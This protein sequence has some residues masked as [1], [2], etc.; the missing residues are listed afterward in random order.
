LSEGWNRATVLFRDYGGAVA[1][2]TVLV[3]AAVIDPGGV[4]VQAIKTA[5][6]AVSAAG[7]FRSAVGCG[8]GEPSGQSEGTGPYN[9]IED[10]AHLVFESPSGGFF[11]FDIPAPKAS[12]CVSGTNL[13]NS[14]ATPLST[15]IA[16][17]KDNAC[18]PDGTTGITFVEG[19]RLKKKNMKY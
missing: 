6:D 12:I 3:A 17:F 2:V 19:V 5:L 16:A 9:K 13:L 15:F 8:S 1:K 7:L 4:V 14:T 11:S 18:D 10:R